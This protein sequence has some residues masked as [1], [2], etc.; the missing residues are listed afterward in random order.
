LWVWAIFG[1]A[2][3][4]IWLLLAGAMRLYTRFEYTK[5]SLWGIYTCAAA[6][7]GL[8]LH[9]G[10]SRLGLPP[11]FGVPVGLGMAA[12]LFVAL[13]SALTQAW[14]S[15]KIARYDTTIEQLFDREYVEKNRLEDARERVHGESLKRQGSAQRKRDMSERRAQLVSTIDSWQQGGGIARVRSLK[16]EEWQKAYKAMDELSLARER[17][18]LKAEAQAASSRPDGQEQA[19]QIRTELAVLDL[20][21]IERHMPAEDE[22][23]DIEGLFREEARVKTSLEGIKTDLAEWRRKRSDFLRQKIRLD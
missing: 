1:L 16:V 13:A 14:L 10:T 22:S 3:L 2:A 5:K 21:V 17:D 9:V 11:V 18:R 8:G 15:V 4:G 7:L 23:P 12:A 19:R 20:T 6:S